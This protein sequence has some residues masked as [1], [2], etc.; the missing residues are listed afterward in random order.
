MEQVHNGMFVPEIGLKGLLSLST[1]E[2]KR[3]QKATYNPFWNE[4]Q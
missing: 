2:G 4:E 1:R 3:I